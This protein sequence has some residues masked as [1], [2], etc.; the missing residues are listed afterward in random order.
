MQPN[1]CGCNYVKI[2]SEV[3]KMISKK[4]FENAVKVLMKNPKDEK[5]L[6]IFWDYNVQ[7]GAIKVFEM[8]IG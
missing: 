7:T 6:K 5:A 4:E 8:K 1:I 2:K 3:I